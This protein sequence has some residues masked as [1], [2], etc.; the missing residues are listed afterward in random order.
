MIN[1]KQIKA[2]IEAAQVFAAEH[3]PDP[4][5]AHQVCRNALC[6]F[7]QLCEMHGLGAIDRVLLHTAALL[8]DT[9]YG[10]DA[11]KHNKA[12]RDLILSAELPGIS[13]REQMVIACIARYHSG[14]PPN[15]AHKVYRDLKPRERK[16]V[17]RLAALLRIADGLDRSHA[18]SAKA[19][20]IERDS[21]LVRIHVRQSC[22]NPDDI[23]AGLR[24]GRLF[25]T[26]FGVTLDIVGE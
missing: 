17:V 24:K 14:G 7:D 16:S 6:L 22:A 13:V 26:V 18:A 11:S 23:A 20:R 4:E 10:T 9:G 3:D 25:E 8:H 15:S 2:C 19:I 5:H 1:A 12:S 21:T